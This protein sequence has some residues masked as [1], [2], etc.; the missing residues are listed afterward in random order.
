MDF[1]S[2]KNMVS[3][4]SISGSLGSSAQGERL[5]DVLSVL[6]SAPVLSG[7]HDSALARF[8][9]MFVIDAFILN[10]DRNNGNWGLLTKGFNVELAPVFDNGNAFCNKRNRSFL[11]SRIDNEELLNQDVAVG[12]SFFT[13]DEDHHIHPFEFL[14]NC[15][16]RNCRDALRWLLMT[17]DLGSIEDIVN[18]IPNEAF[19]IQ[20]VSDRQ[21]EYYCRI[22]QIALKK[23][24]LADKH[25]P[26]S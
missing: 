15:S 10:N 13:D 19:G 22:L 2:I 21:K 17:V 25:M 14:K 23:L 26:V 24:I 20:V 16:D 4:D 9:K 3:E 11:E 1:A 18:D 6:N 8:W 7:M 5:S 12:T